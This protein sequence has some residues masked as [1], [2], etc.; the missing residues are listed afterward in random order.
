MFDNKKVYELVKECEIQIK[1]IFDYHDEIALIN[2]NKVLSAMQ[3]KHLAERHFVGST[4][5]G[6]NDIGRDITEEI[7]AMVLGG[8]TALVRPHIVSGTHAIWLAI[9]GVLRPGDNMIAVTGKPYDTIFANIGVDNQFQNMGMLSEYNI[10][11]K[12]VD[13]KEDNSIDFEGIRSAIDSKT[14]LIYIQR[15]TGYSL[16]DALTISRIEEICSFVR[17]I[18][19]NLVIF[20]DNCYGEF[21]E[22]KEPLDVG[23]DLIAGSLIKNPGGGLA[24]NGGYV[25]GKEKYVDMV[26]ARLSAPS[27][28]YEVG[29]SL[30]VTRSY[31]QGLF[32]A[33]SVVNSAVKG[34]ILTSAVFEKLGFEVFPKYNSNRSDIIQAIVLNSKEA[35]L[36]YCAAIQSSSPVDS[37]VTPEAW[38]MPGYDEPVVM[39]AGNFI[40]GSSIE[41]SADSPMKPPYVV[42][43]QGGLTLSLIHI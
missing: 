41:L 16:R 19:P 17:A 24:Q 3:E 15:S 40:Q 6:Y 11:Y 23:A 22:D 1:D 32:V 25:C 42:Y 35:V 20:V 39:A 30:G 33:P 36:K 2:Q 10:S 13:L 34:A 18:N 4:G 14:K 21:I 8:E 27:I 28:A 5:Y 26:A 7:Y 31:L 37:Y 43:Q 38:D 29:A 12:Q 9:S